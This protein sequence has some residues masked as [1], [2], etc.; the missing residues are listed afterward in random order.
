[1]I[2]TRCC[3]VDEARSSVD[4]SVLIVIGAALGLGKALETSGAAPA[5]VGVAMDLVGEHPW[6]ALAAVYV[7]TVLLT[8]V[9]TN[10]AAVALAFPLA[11]ATA[12]RLHVNPFPFLMAIMIANG[13][14]SSSKVPSRS[15]RRAGATAE[16]GQPCAAAMSAARATVASSSRMPMTIARSRQAG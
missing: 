16:R 2:A 6:A 11:L 3:S 4:W 9:L 13:A 12:E 15:R 8:E 14:S 1:M 7:V 10:N 5:A